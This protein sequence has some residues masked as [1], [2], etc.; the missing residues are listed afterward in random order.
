M[1]LNRICLFVL[2]LLNYY[3]EYVLSCFIRRFF[4]EKSLCFVYFINSYFTDFDLFVVVSFPFS[5]DCIFFVFLKRW[6]LCFFLKILLYCIYF[7]D[8]FLTNLD[9]NL[10]PFIWNC[11]VSMY[12]AVLIINYFFVFDMII[13]LYRVHR[14]IWYWIK[15]FWWF[16]F[17]IILAGMY[18]AFFLNEPFFYLWIDH[19]LKASFLIHFLLN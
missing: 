11:I 6:C 3:S 5:I 17:W 16:Y 7:I 9:L 13:I 14:L 12:L 1:L 19:Y 15:Y 10:I 2:L 18:F 4:C 8:W